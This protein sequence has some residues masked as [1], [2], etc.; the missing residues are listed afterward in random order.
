MFNHKYRCNIK[1]YVK[2]YKKKNDTIEG[3]ELNNNNKKLI[4]LKI[5]TL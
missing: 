5:F 1:N 2:I 4:K 3:N